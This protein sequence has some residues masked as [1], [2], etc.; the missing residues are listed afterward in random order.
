M[1]AVDIFRCGLS[2]VRVAHLAFVSHLKASC[3]TL[4]RNPLYVVVG[5]D[6]GHGVNGDGVGLL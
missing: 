1:T 6:D 3:L 5:S 2:L 4:L